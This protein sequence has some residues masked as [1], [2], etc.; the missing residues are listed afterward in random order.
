M[1]EG[2]LRAAE[3]LRIGN[4]FLKRQNATFRDIGAKN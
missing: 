1:R 2:G 4:F 3:H